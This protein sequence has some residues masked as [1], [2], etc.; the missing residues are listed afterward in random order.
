MV[1]PQQSWRL[2][3]S[4]IH[5]WGRIYSA[6]LPFILPFSELRVKGET[7]RQNEAR[8]KYSYI[9]IYNVFNSTLI[10]ISLFN[11]HM[12]KYIIKHSQSDIVTFLDNL[13]QA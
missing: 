2:R 7:S 6:Q 3:K 4:F 9:F 8:E 10:Y 12:S 13:K 5:I 11:G 1:W